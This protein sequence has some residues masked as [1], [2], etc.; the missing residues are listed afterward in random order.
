LSLA[1]IAA[2]TVTSATVT[3]ATLHEE[4][5]DVVLSAILPLT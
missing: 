1:P 4:D 5:I 2:A 3:S